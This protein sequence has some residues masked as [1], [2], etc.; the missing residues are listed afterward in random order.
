MV[1]V[2]AP[3]DDVEESTGL[4]ARSLALAV[5]AVTALLAAL[6]W[7]L[8]GRTLRPVEAIRRE[9]AQIGATDLRRRVPVP[10]GDDE[11]ARLARTMNAMLDRVEDASDRQRRFVGDASHELRTPLA[12]MRSEIEVDLAH[13]DRADLVATHHSVLDEAVGMQRLVDDLLRL[14]RADGTGDGAGDGTGHAGGDTA[15]R[16]DLVVAGEVS[17][18]RADA[19]V[20]IDATDLAP[21]PVAADEAELRR[22]AANVLD[23]ATRH[24]RSHVV[25]A[26]RAGDGTAELTVTDDGPGIPADQAERIF[27]RFARLD[28]ARSA[29]DGG[30]GL[31]LAI[32]REIAER[33]GGTLTVDVGHRDGARFVLRLPPSPG[34]GRTSGPDQPAST[35]SGG[36]S[37]AA[38]SARWRSRIWFSS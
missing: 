27:E 38:S 31:G 4:L 15:V 2:A 26:V 16:L 21:V 9:V 34:P 7:A 11:V 18:A 12:R 19:P 30:A 36:S 23:N 22:I 33:H 29:A 32:A 14:A 1:H 8:A 6:V 3:L 35:G 24:A 5:P 20:A 28:D 13:P 37:A 25:V 10:P 17:R